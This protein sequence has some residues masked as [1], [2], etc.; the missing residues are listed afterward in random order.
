MMASGDSAVTAERQLRAVAHARN[1]GVTPMKARRVIDLIRGRDARDALAV[2]QFAPQAA[3]SPVSKVL[4]SAMANAQNNLSLD[5]DTLVVSK[6]YVDEGPT[7]KRFRERA[8][9]RAYRIRK[10]TSHITVEVESLPERRSGGRPAATGRQPTGRQTSGRQS[11]SS[12]KATQ[13]RS[14]R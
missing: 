5:P 12:K 11:G 9:G 4:A 6:A 13:T 14:A 8:Q 2:L 10:R 1:I 3:S 7:L